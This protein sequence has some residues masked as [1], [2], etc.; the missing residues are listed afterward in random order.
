MDWRIAHQNRAHACHV[1][2]AAAAGRVHKLRVQPGPAA[3]QHFQQEVRQLLGLRPGEEFEVTF[4][5][6]APTTGE[7]ATCMSSAVHVRTPGA[8]VL[9]AVWWPQQ[10]VLLLQLSSAQCVRQPRCRLLHLPNAG[11]QLLLEGMQAFD[12]AAHCAAVSAARRLRA[13]QPEQAPPVPAAAAAGGAQ[14]GGQAA[15]QLGGS[16][17]GG[18]GGG[19]DGLRG[20]G[21]GH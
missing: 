4:E 11:E 9:P 21:A 15:Q 18:G 5:C 6:R 17:G 14:A 13:K 7:R 2:G 1:P 20:G 3:H 10:F 8:V 12:A 16:S 19:R